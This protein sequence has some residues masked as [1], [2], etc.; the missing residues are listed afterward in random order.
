M[1]V[2]D[3]RTAPDRVLRASILISCAIVGAL[4]VR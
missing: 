3:G 1:D 2:V 4:L